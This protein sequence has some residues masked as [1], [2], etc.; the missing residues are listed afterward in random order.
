MIIN[1]FQWHHIVWAVASYV[2]THLSHVYALHSLVNGAPRYNILCFV[3]M[4]MLCKWVSDGDSACTNTAVNRDEWAVILERN[5][6]IF[7]Y[8]VVSVSSH[9]SRAGQ[10]V[11]TSHIFRNKGFVS[12]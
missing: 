11:H 1:N 8:N 7:Y 4:L 2:I 12:M 9:Y 6:G 3:R 10:A 5:D